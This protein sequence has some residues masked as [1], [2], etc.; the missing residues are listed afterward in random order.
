VTDEAG[1]RELTPVPG[2]G[3][4]DSSLAEL[5]QQHAGSALRLAILLC[6]SRELA[7]DIVQDA[8]IRVGGRLRQI[9]E[10]VAFAAYLRQCVINLVRSHYRHQAVARRFLEREKHQPER[11]TVDPTDFETRDALT[12]A[13]QHIP[14]RQREAI[15]CRFYLDYSERQT[16][17][18][19]GCPKGTVKSL[20]SRGLDNLRAQF[21]TETPPTPAEHEAPA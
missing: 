16:A 14:E 4:L 1:A 2:A 19:L 6:G 20:V 3:A 21:P 9:R 18:L 11:A 17:E 13:L 8:F 15:V 10:P 5:Y 7:E 12:H